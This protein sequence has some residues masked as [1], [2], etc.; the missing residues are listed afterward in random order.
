[1]PTFEQGFSDLEKATGELIKSAT[2]FTTIC[3]QLQKVASDGVLSKLPKL[4]EK[5]TNAVE[6]L[7]SEVDHTMTAWPFSPEHEEQ[8][9]RDHYPAELH[10][11]AREVGLKLQEIDQRFIAFPAIVRILPADRAVR[12]DKR[13]IPA[14]RPSKLASR[15]RSNQDKPLKLSS[16]KFLEVLFDAYLIRVG[17]EG[18]GKVVKLKG[19]YDLLTLLP[20][21][22]TEYDQTD[23]ARDL[24][25]LDRS[26]LRKTKTGMEFSLPADTGAKGG[27]GIRIADPDG[28][29]V[30]YSSIRFWE[31]TNESSE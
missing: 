30:T 13:K 29:T 7:R 19:I 24:L 23:F 6:S 2:R 3:K 15:L 14:I 11:A 27:K 10:I 12:I 5:L 17:K 18:I 22:Q 16:E 25:M 1:M 26:G 28:N 4:T 9:L 20:G 8:H 21:S 31:T